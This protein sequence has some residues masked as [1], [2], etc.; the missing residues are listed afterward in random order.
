MFISQYSFDSYFYFVLTC[1][2]KFLVGKW[3]QL[4]MTPF[5]WLP[6]NGVSF[7]WHLK[8][9]FL[10]MCKWG[11]LCMAS[12]GWLPLHVQMG[13]VLYDIL[14][15]TSFIYNQQLWSVLY[16]TLG[17]T[18]PQIRE[19]WLPQVRS[20]T[21]SYISVAQQMGNQSITKTKQTIS[22]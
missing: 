2:S 1:S 7:V 19:L 13:S 9:G 14:E 22:H 6:L 20:D 5:K 18:S 21:V 15:G 3:G 4:C 8:G 17:V 10:Y 12:Q 11:E 16:G